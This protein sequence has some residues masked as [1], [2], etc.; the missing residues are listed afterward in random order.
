LEKINI[1]KVPECSLLIQQSVEQMNKQ[2]IV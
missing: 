1:I 2:L